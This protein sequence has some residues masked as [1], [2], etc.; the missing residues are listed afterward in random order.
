MRFR[1]LIAL[2]IL[3][4]MVGV[5]PAQAKTIVSL[6][7]QSHGEYYDTSYRGAGH[8]VDAE[9]WGEGNTANPE[10]RPSIRET[11]QTNDIEG[12][13]GEK[14]VQIAYD[15]TSM[16]STGH[17]D[18]RIVRDCDS[19]SS[20]T[21]ANGYGYLEPYCAPAFDGFCPIKLS[22]VQYAIYDRDTQNLINDSKHCRGPGVDTQTKC[23]AWEPT[24]EVT[25]AARI[26]GRRDDGSTWLQ[27]GGD[28]QRA[29]T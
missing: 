16:P 29:G 12:P 13:E 11:V 5:S 2:A 17:Y 22:K 10:R 15:W 27:T 18:V 24:G 6:G 28:P 14:C 1:M 9:W 7:D 19:N 25:T 21:N 23:E 20:I 26:W 8:Y 4:L 3:G